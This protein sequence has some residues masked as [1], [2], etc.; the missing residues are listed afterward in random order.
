MRMN[1]K[2]AFGLALGM[3]LVLTTT[4]AVQAQPMPGM[5]PTSRNLG[6]LPPVGLPVVPVFEGAYENE[7][8]SVTYSF[9][10][11][12]RSNTETVS[13]PLGMNNRVEPAQFNGMQP[14]FFSTGRHAG[15]F[16]VTVPASMRD[17]E[18]WWYIKTGDHDELK[19]PGRRGRLGYTLDKTPRPAGTVAPFVSFTEGGPQ[20]QD[21]DGIIAD[22]A[23]TVRAGV[24]VTLSIHAHDPSIRDMTD[25][26][27]AA[28][29]PVRI[30][31][32]KHQG[33]GEVTF[34]RHPSSEEPVA[35]TELQI[36]RGVSPPG[37]EQTRISSGTGSAS[38]IA[39]FSQPGEY[40]IRTL[41]DNW[42]AMDSN[43]NDQCC[44]TNAYQRVTVTP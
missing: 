31:W 19:V 42:A 27:N 1:L 32:Y 5:A 44:W 18:V 39:T 13:I 26:R 2:T 40:M 17:G 21:P 24:P 20:G 30:S 43:Q 41:A 28:G 12:N 6:L 37:P 10:F 36:S 16:T 4:A 11:L 25:T 15:V 23:L 22:S 9:G 38:V 33:P 3:F 7:D 34:E 35:L 14:S 29:I 8:G